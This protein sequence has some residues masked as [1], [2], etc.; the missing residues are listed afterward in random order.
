MKINEILNNNFFFG[1][2]FNPQVKAVILKNRFPDE[3][4]ACQQESWR[5]AAKLMK[6]GVSPNRITLCDGV[7]EIGGEPM[8]AEGHTW[9]EV[10]GSIFDPTAAQFSGRKSEHF[11]QI[12][13]YKDDEELL[14]FLRGN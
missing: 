8:N 1:S 6:L 10:D 4:L 3:S 13:D 14:S 12:E 7:Y 2:G 9:L 5:W 11:Y